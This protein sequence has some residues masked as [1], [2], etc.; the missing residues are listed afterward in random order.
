M[1][2]QSVRPGLLLIVAQRAMVLGWD[3]IG[4]QGSAANE[5]ILGE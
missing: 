5:Q 3:L 1:S 4:Q 2:D